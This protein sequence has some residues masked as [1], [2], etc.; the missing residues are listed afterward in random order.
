MGQANALFVGVGVHKEI[1][2]VVYIAEGRGAEVVSL[3]AIG[4]RLKDI[5][6]LAHKRQ[7]KGK[8]LRFG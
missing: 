2:A 8:Q 3:G 5:D 4:P 6:A 1:S 7:G